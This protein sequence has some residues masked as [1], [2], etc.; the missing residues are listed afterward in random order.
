MSEPRERLVSVLIPTFNGQRYLA[1]ALRSAV[2]QTYAQLEIVICDDGSSDS[3]L[4]IARAFA[5]DDPRVRIHL[6]EARLGVVGN[7]ERCLAL[8]SGTYVKYLMQDDILEPHAVERLLEALLQADDVVLATSRRT[9]IDERGEPLPDGPEVRSLYARDALVDGRVLGDI[10]LEE[11]LNLIGEPSVVLFRRSALG[12]AAPFSLGGAQYRYLADLAL[13]MTL[14]GRGRAAYLVEPLSHFRHH[15]DQDSRVR[16]NMVVSLLEWQRL[17]REARGLG[18]LSSDASWERSCRRWLENAP[19]FFRFCSGVSEAASLLQATVVANT[20]LLRLAE[21]R[22]R[23]RQ[24]RTALGAT[25]SCLHA[26]ALFPV[27]GLWAE[28][29]H[30]A[31]A[32]LRRRRAQRARR[33]AMSMGNPRRAA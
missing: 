28:R 11:N 14:L 8:A 32:P 15:V 7:F 6:N 4:E 16:A 10:A 9:R 1:D 19:F 27:A 30:V 22:G 33:R 29:I 13:W 12:E 17:H 24:V 18:F 21:G 31:R 23:W 26:A 2:A 20:E 5:A 25:I 3:T